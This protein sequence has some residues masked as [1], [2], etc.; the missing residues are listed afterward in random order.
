MQIVAI[1]GSPRKNF[2]SAALLKHAAD[3]AKS[4]GAEVE[5]LHLYDYQYTGCVSCF[6]CKNLKN[7][8][9]GHCVVADELSPVLRK[10]MQAD[11]LLLASPIYLG[12]VTGM[13]RSFLERLIFAVSSYDEFGGSVFDGHIS[14]AF[15]FSMN[16]PEA[17]I[18]HGN[19]WM[20][21]VKNNV[22]RLSRLGGSTTWMASYDTY[23]F[24]NYDDYAA[25]MFDLAGKKK[26]RDEQFPLDCKNA[27]EMGSSLARNL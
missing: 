1:N 20:E 18:T 24:D 25:D 9:R 11:A 17:A 10:C 14:S 21:M 16:M 23:Q 22:H 19:S 8:N 3:G 27:F 13:M 7:Q 5:L 15:F 4:A 6:G 2:N 12:N 26:H